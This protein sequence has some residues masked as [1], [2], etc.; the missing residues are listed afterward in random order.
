M[1]ETRREGQIFS[2]V[3]APQEEEVYRETVW[4]FEGKERVL[5]VGAHRLQEVA[6]GR[7]VFSRSCGLHGDNPAVGAYPHCV[8]SHRR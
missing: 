2:E 3:V 7:L 8:L 6:L 4:H 1:E 5:E